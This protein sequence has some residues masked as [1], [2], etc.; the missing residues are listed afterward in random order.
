MIE[1]FSSSPLYEKN[2]FLQKN[3]PQLCNILFGTIGSPGI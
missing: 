1:N 3:F 2:E